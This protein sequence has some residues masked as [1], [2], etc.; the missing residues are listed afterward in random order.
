MSLNLQLNVNI[1]F[2]WVNSNQAHIN[3]QILLIEVKT[4]NQIFRWIATDT[5][6][7]TFYGLIFQEASVY[8]QRHYTQYIRQRDLRQVMTQN[9]PKWHRV[10]ITLHIYP[11]WQHDFEL[12]AHTLYAYI[13]RHSYTQNTVAR[14]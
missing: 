3:S 4:V 12:F 9:C 2:E 11:A 6:I 8:I 10:Y 7:S 1:A 14:D 5:M 13:D